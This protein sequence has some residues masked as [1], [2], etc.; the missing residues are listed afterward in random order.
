VDVAIPG[1]VTAEMPVCC[2]RRAGQDLA[3]G[4][5]GDPRLRASDVD[6]H[7]PTNQECASLFT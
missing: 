4:S 1:P 2:N 6:V 3:S 7:E 5:C